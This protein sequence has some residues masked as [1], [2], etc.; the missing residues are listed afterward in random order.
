MV[1]HPVENMDAILHLVFSSFPLATICAFVLLGQLESHRHLPVCTGLVA[2]CSSGA[3]CTGAL[4][5]DFQRTLSVMEMINW[6][7]NRYPNKRHTL[8]GTRAKPGE[9]ARKLKRG[10]CISFTVEV[11]LR[12]KADPLKRVTLI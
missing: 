9:H 5:Y 12:P 1:V 3:V 8:F 2:F 4:F 10:S 11:K 7:K 6:L